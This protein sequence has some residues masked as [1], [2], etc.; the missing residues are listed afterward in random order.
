M[1]KAM[2]GT[3]PVNSPA[4]DRSVMPSA[5]SMLP[6]M[7]PCTSSAIEWRSALEAISV[8][9]TDF[10]GV[11]IISAVSLAFGNSLLS[12]A[13]PNA[14]AA[15]ASWPLT[16]AIIVDKKYPRYTKERAVRLGEGVE[17]A[18][19]SVAMLSGISEAGVLL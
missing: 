15:A 2:P 11:A 18:I 14:S 6:E 12:S 5:A 8:A 4:L 13:L 7:T 3:P 9:K 1:R 19:H 17:Q 16:S 10:V